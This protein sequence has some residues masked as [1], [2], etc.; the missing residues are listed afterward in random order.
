MTGFWIYMI[1]IVVVAGAMAYGAY[2][3]SVPMAWLGVG[4]A[5]IVG[6]GLMGGVK[7]LPRKNGSHTD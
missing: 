2:L 5:I 3:L 1:G 6:L 7:K 4:V